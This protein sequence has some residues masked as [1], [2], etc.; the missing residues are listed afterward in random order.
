MD[1]EQ[2]HVV[3]QPQKSP[4]IPKFLDMDSSTEEEQES[5]VHY[6]KKAPKTPEFVDTGLKNE[7]EPAVNYQRCIVMYSTEDEQE[8]AIKKLQKASKIPRFVDT[9]SGTENEQELTIKKLQKPSKIHDEDPQETSPGPAHKEL[10]K[11]PKKLPATSC[12]HILTSGVRK[13]K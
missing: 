2:E 10:A 9:G 4:K 5:V 8:L 13:D 6:P 12:T 1:D 3:K 11:P 7:Q